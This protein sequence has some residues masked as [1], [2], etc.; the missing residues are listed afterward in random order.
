MESLSP[1][2]TEGSTLQR[3][4]KRHTKIK[5]LKVGLVYSQLGRL[6][7][8]LVLFAINLPNLTFRNVTFSFN[9]SN[10]YNFFPLI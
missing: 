4:I 2:V 3:A 5:Q 10:K 6:I 1:I 8:L 9:L 7:F